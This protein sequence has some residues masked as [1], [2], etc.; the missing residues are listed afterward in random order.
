[1]LVKGG[2]CTVFMSYGYANICNYLHLHIGCGL[3]PKF[4]HPWFELTGNINSVMKIYVYSKNDLEQPK[5]CFS[6]EPG[7][8]ENKKMVAILFLD[9]WKTELQNVGH[10]NVQ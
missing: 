6:N 3:L 8:L 4:A 2:K 7:P 9:H 10:S 5:G 1:M